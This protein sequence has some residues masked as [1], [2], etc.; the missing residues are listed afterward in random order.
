MAHLAAILFFLGLL[1]ALGVILEMIVKA[2]WAEISAAFRGVP[3][4]PE[5]APAAGRAKAA[6]RRPAA[7]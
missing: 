4:A 6:P 7:A 2:N 5:P 3:P 1:A